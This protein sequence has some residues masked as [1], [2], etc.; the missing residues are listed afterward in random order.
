MFVLKASEMGIMDK[1]TIEG[2]GIPGIVLMENAARGVASVIK[3][4]IPGR[5]AV[6]VCGKGNN[7]GDGLAVA[8]NLI[9]SGYDVKIFLL[10]EPGNLKGDARINYDVLRG[11]K[12]QIVSVKREIDLGDLFSECENADFIVD[13]IFGT[14]LSKPVEGFYAAV[15]DI[16]NKSRTP[17]IS[18]DIPSGLF[19]D[20]GV[21]PE[22]TFIKANVTVTFAFPKLVHIMAPACKYVGDVFVVDISIP[23]KISER[24]N[25]G[26]YVLTRDKVFDV[27][28]GRDINSHK[29]NF[30]FLAVVGGSCGK[31]GAPSMSALAA[32]RTG[33]GLVSAIVPRDLNFVFEVKLTEPMTIPIM[34]A[35]RGHFNANS[36]DEVVTSLKNSKFTAVA[37]GPGLGWNRDTEV[38]VKEILEN[39]D[40]PFVI[41]A[42][43][44]NSLSK[45][46]DILKNLKKTAI[47]TP[48]GGEFSR[49]TGL[50]TSEIVADPVTHAVNFAKEHGV[51][52][53]LKG[54]RT[55][56][57]T[58]EGKAFINIIG[59]PGMAT[60]GTGDVLTGIIGAFVA[61]GI[62]AEKAAT[63]GVFLHSLAGDMA[64]EKFGQESLVATDLIELLPEAIKLLKQPLSEGTEIPFVSSMREI[65]GV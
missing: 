42:D 5:K 55:V 30:G 21:L 49:L 25:P 17:V 27:F 9:N 28:P 11:M 10:S 29:Y 50:P 63:A 22:G 35:E 34:S 53:V 16:I 43:G 19:A 64:K 20:T 62:S 52:V 3:K 48:H 37:I 54:G 56:V 4:K 39:V 40:L 45:N 51:V 7:G 24:H 14:G 65:V 46:V 38:F 2:V 57:A 33:V 12:V 6:I 32:L 1:E 31:T 13:A 44:L 8:R 18:V 41:D 60:A 59:N 36:V 26:R 61:M 47:L 23:A 58:P 15:I